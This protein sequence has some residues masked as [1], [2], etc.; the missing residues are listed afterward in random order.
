MDPSKLDPHH[1]FSSIGAALS[2]ESRPWALPSTME[3]CGAFFPVT[4][5]D[6]GGF[7]PVGNFLGQKIFR[8]TPPPPPCTA[9]LTCLTTSWDGTWNGLNAIR[10][11]SPK[12]H[13]LQ[14]E[15]LRPLEFRGK[16]WKGVSKDA[17]DF[18]SD[19]CAHAPAKRP[20][21]GDALRHVWLQPLQPYQVWSRVTFS[22]AHYLLMQSECHMLASCW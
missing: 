19:L 13:Y 22:F 10:P 20:S 5:K 14:A 1:T 2:Q 18:V 9:F 12:S 3:K 8:S 6:R 16:S 11:L 17:R 4:F 15:M 21:A 7:F